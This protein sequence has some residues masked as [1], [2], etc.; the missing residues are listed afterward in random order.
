MAPSVPQKHHAAL[1]RH[2]APIRPEHRPP[3]GGGGVLEDGIQLD[4]TGA[5]LQQI[6]SVP[7]EGA[8]D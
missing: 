4:G 6:P 2:S 3:E 7:I 8:R 5:I 1:G